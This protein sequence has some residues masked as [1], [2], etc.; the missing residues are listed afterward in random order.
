M[1]IGMRRRDCQRGGAGLR[2]CSSRGAARQDRGGV[3][4]RVRKETAATLRSE[5]ARHRGFVHVLYMMDYG[6]CGL[7]LGIGGWGV[8]LR[9]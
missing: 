5:R 3:V 6:V 8:G 2:R 9:V 1:S 4:W 7:G